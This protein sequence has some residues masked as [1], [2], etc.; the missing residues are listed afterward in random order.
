MS[1]DHIAVDEHRVAALHVFRHTCLA[2]DL[3]EIVGRLHVDVEAVLA[4]VGGVTLAT[5]AL[6]V[7]VK[8]GLQ[9]IGDR[10]CGEGHESGETGEAD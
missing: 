7:L 9:R 10:R 3:E 6:R 2:A 4:Q 5:A 8:R 1:V